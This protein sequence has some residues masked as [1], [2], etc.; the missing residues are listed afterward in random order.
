MSIE[1]TT[2]RRA[3]WYRPVSIYRS[4]ALRPRMYLAVGAGALALLLLPRSLS[5]NVREASSWIIGGLVYLASAVRS[6]I[7]TKADVIASRAKRVDDSRTVILVIVLLAIGASFVSIAGLINEAKDASRHA[8]LWY[9]ALAASTILVS[10]IVTQVVFTLHYAHE[11]YR[12]SSQGDGPEAPRQ[13]LEFPGE[14]NPDYWDFLYFTTSIGATSQTSDVA[15]RSRAM[16]RLVTVHAVVS[17]FFN[18]TVLA[19]TINLA[20]SLI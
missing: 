20:A 18:T 7:D 14:P 13:G 9:L 10:W 5:A 8:K 12:P 1:S 16:R 6:M 3:R 19:L 15:I 17:F 4:I 2:A 11:Y